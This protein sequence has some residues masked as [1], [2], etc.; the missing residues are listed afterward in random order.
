MTMTDIAQK[1]SISVATVSNALSGK[2][3]VSDSLRMEILRTAAEMGYDLSKHTTPRQKPKV[4][5]VV[6]DISISFCHQ[7]T[8]GI[9]MAAAEADV[10]PRIV[11]MNLTQ[12]TDP[13]RENRSIT[14]S[15]A[16]K[17][18]QQILP[19]SNG[20]IYVSA[21]PRD[22]TDI[23]P[24]TVIP[25]VYAYGYVKDMGA[26]CVNYDDMHGAYLATQHLIQA[27]RQRI[28]MIS[29]P[30]NSIPMTKRL[31][32]YQRALLDGSLPFDPSLISIGE[33][34]PENGYQSMEQFMKLTHRPDSVFC[35]S[36]HI[37]CG[38]LRFSEDHSLRVPEDLAIVGFDNYEFSFLQKTPIT[39]VAPPCNEI[40][41]V[42]FQQLWN[43]I[44]KV[45]TE[46]NNIKLPCSLLIRESSRAANELQD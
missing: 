28:A 29:G 32:G 40:G 15:L 42:A 4:D 8:C 35:Q 23:L 7:I 6:E 43:K 36:D 31:N 41:R 21:Y 22:L 30:I 11:N 16:K 37:A 24:Q 18:F 14:A 38:V 26:V 2:G 10:I 45:P 9:S 44:K 17:C 13:V 33:W 3:R 19:D 12:Y 39:T 5:V 25:L 34:K 1:L 20:I 46:E 27:G